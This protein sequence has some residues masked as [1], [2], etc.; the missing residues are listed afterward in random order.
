VENNLIKME[1]SEE[2]GDMAFSG[3]GSGSL[4]TLSAINAII[5]IYV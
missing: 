4:I 3:G 5:Q 1:K 2:I